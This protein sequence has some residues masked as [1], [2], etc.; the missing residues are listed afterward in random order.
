MYNGFCCSIK[1][2][3]INILLRRCNVF[4]QIV[5]RGKNIAMND[6]KSSQR[7]SQI[8]LG[9]YQIAGRNTT[10]NLL[11]PFQISH[12][13]MP[14]FRP[15]LRM[16]HRDM[17]VP[18]FSDY[19]REAKNEDDPKDNRAEQRK[20]FTYTMVAAG[21]VGSCYAA[22]GIVHAFV[23]SMSVTADVLAIAKI[24]IKLKDIPEGKSV[25]FKW[26]GKPLFVRHRTEAEIEDVR[27][28]KLSSL[29]DPESD[30]KRVKDPRWLILIGVC[31]H[32]GCVPIANAGD[33][34]GYYCPCHGSHFDASGRVRKGPAPLNL[35]VPNYEFLDEDTL[36]VG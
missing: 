16:S 14:L 35:A 1:A 27:S 23:R 25:T 6:R 3:I 21:A 13:G 10:L 30:D 9:L 28:V 32:L 19:R 2:T 17:E 4:Q 36:L 12:R 7:N 31:T 33:F 20:A 18:D 34:G 15:S 5:R 11:A 22:K 24:E 26:R 8:Y 29:R